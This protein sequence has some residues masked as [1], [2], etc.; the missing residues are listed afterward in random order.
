MAR[1]TSVRS[2]DPR[3][4][5]TLDALSA[6]KD[7][8][9]SLGLHADWRDFED[10]TRGVQNPVVHEDD[11]GSVT[12]IIFPIIASQVSD[13]SSEQ[14]DIMVLGEDPSDE[15]FASNVRHILEWVKW[16]NKMFM[17]I[18]RHEWRR[19]KFGTGVWKVYYDPD[20]KRTVNGI[21]RIDPI[22][23]VNFFPDPKVKE[24]W[25]LDE[26]DFM[27]H[28]VMKSTRFIGEMY[29]DSAKDIK[30]IKN[31]SYD[32]EIFDGETADETTALTSE[33][34]PLIEIWKKKDGNLHRM[35]VAG[36]TLCYDSEH[37]KNLK[38]SPV[39]EN[40]RYPFVVTPCYPVEGRLWGMG[41]TELLI[42][43]QDL[44]ND[45]D[46]Q[47]RMNARLMGNIQI[48][49][50]LASG[51]NPMKWTNKAGLKIPARDPHAINPLTP[52]TMPAYITNRR[53]TALMREAE[54]ISGRPDVVEGRKHGGTR[55]ASAII[56]LQEAGG[57][58]VRHK[59]MYLQ[60]GLNQVFDLSLDYVKQFFTEEQAFRILGKNAEDNPETFI[61][62]RGSKLKEIPRLIP[63]I[64]QETGEAHLRQLIGESGEPITKD[65][66]F[67]IRV[68][69]GAGLPGNKAFL[70]QALMEL[71]AGGIISVPEARR[72]LRDMLDWPVADPDSMDNLA[73]MMM[74]GGGGMP[75]MEAFTAGGGEAI[76]PEI[77]NQLIATLQGGGLGGQ[78]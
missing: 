38:G 62:F 18:D 65:A 22:S 49:V 2:L 9:E 32:L 69:I 67:D 7:A 1:G 78:G 5:E 41:D 33:K 72:A 12:N 6:A 53:D 30:I 58:R 74:P 26:G 37:D 63:E 34:T 4:V 73:P 56:A 13:I 51:I 47:I 29:P 61:W 77:M 19:L 35:V 11:P 68:S 60:E 27:V 57:K 14:L 59:K 25:S 31:P 46:D 42:P 54:I 17:K 39:Y 3:V 8:K 66:Q 20:M 23:P 76:P 44:V 45:L 40:G 50:G 55:A 43:T 24:P 15:R 71:K 48:I 10:Y 36:E 75:G 64:N 52:P 28:A 21:I 16:R 70:Y